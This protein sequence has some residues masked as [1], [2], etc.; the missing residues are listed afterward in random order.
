[1]DDNTVIK[2][3][4]VFG[5]IGLTMLGGYIPFMSKNFKAVKWTGIANSFAGGVFLGVGMLH[6]LPEA[7]EALSHSFPEF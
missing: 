7:H 6:L 2:V 5:F 3:C 1:M 4:S